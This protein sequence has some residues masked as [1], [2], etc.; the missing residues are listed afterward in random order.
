MQF[1]WD[2]KR[3]CEMQQWVL[4]DQPIASMLQDRLRAQAMTN[5]ELTALAQT[6][7]NLGSLNTFMSK[8]LGRM[9]A[10]KVTDNS[11]LDDAYMLALQDPDQAAC[12]QE[13][14]LLNG[15]K[16]IRIQGPGGHG[17]TETTLH[18]R[19][20]CAGQSESHCHSNNRQSCT[21]FAMQRNHSTHSIWHHGGSLDSF[22]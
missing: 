12:I 14:T 11:A 22:S 3:H 19:F 1:K 17:K 8:Q 9:Y 5:V 20:A 18:Y 15:P 21:Q 4:A 10:P 6:Y 7:T 2:P 13:A 16:L